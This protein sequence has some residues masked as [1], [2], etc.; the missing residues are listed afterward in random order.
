ML[1][2]LK[3]ELEK[4]KK[5]RKKINFLCLKLEKFLDGALT[6]SKRM[7]SFINFTKHM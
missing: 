6:S 7:E 1:D 3:S 2:I 4:E 5:K